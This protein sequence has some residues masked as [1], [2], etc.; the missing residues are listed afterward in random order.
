MPLETL[1]TELYKTIFDNLDFRDWTALQS[2]SKIVRYNTRPFGERFLRAEDFTFVYS[3]DGLRHF[4]AVAGNFGLISKPRRMNL[5]MTNFLIPHVHEL[6][7]SISPYKSDDWDSN[8]SDCDLSSPALPYFLTAVQSSKHEAWQAYRRYSREQSLL[9]QSGK[10][11]QLL[12]TA[13]EN[14]AKADVEV[15]LHIGDAEPWSTPDHPCFGH[16]WPQDLNDFFN[17]SHSSEPSE[18][19]INPQHAIETLLYAATKSGTNLRALDITPN[20]WHI[21]DIIPMNTLTSV[22]RASL[23]HVERFEMSVKNCIFEYD[24]MTELEYSS[25]LGA[26]VSFLASR[27]LKWMT[28]RC[29]YYQADHTFRDEWRWL[30]DRILTINYPHIERINL[31]D[32]R[33]EAAC[34]ISFLTRHPHLKKL[35][36]EDVTLSNGD[37][38]GVFNILSELE[39]LEAIG[40]RDLFC[41]ET[42]QLVFEDE[43]GD[44]DEG[45]ERSLQY[46]FRKNR[47][48]EKYMEHFV[49]KDS[50]KIRDAL[51]L[52]R[53]CHMTLGANRPPS[54]RHMYGLNWPMLGDD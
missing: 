14:L 37:W 3:H 50:S 25:I 41:F 45:F 43:D 46:Y 22:Q 27:R 21:F 6:D 18:S 28:L 44:D 1:P 48:E 26:F 7:D 5:Y 13:F 23:G 34:L 54:E 11:K 47:Q 31:Y 15:I 40:L 33:T 32:T 52:V 20:D 24:D 9:K 12:E 19:S 17:M 53:D 36:I 8:I 10:D 4:S 35:E 38:N 39:E 42:V 49:E 30:P 51:A 29:N 16:P 2:T